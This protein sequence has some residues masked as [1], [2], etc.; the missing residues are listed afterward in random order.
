MAD[1][2]HIE[3]TD[4]TWNP[5]TGCTKVSQGCKHCYAERDWKRLSAHREKPNAYTG[6]AFT[7]VMCHPERLAQPLRWR[8]PRRIFVNS[9]SDL[10][11][12]D[13]PDAF[14]DQVFAAMAL[15]PQHTF[16]V[17]TK[18]PARMRE[19]MSLGDRRELVACRAY[20][21]LGG[22]MHALDEMEWPLNNVWLGVS[23]EDQ[24]TADERIPLL[25]R[26]RAAVRWVSGEPLL[27]DVTL[28]PDWLTGQYLDHAEDC[29]DDLCALNG[30]IHS[31]VGVVLPQQGVDWVVTGGESG[32]NARP[33]NPNWFRRLRDQCAAH[34]VPFLFKQWGEWAPAR[35]IPH[36]T[37]LKA[38][39]I[40]HFPKDGGEFE[41]FARR[42][43]P[44]DIGYR[45][46]RIGKR[47]AGRL[48][49]GITHDAY[50]EGRP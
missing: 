38:E 31:C 40:G 3:W 27:G 7:D 37:A 30:D 29:T 48:L 28:D 5:V 10:F 42:P 23:I 9:M 45:M 46:G 35:Q 34:G 41:T 1:K 32:P 36:G 15:A 25:I 49:D 12:P 2:T 13:V 47:R 4:A 26:T 14:I 22:V 39:D 18:R 44:G 16:Q 50:P 21:L 19:Y 33:S 24:S 11:H 8:A 6:R 20:A 43:I 17:L